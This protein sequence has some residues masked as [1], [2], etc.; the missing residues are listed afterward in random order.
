M[1]PLHERNEPNHDAWQ[2]FQRV[3]DQRRAVRHF[4]GAP[5]ADADMRAILA[6]AQTAPSSRNSQPYQL[7]WV[8]D[9]EQRGK[10]A[11]AC[12][13][14]RAARGAGAFVV[15]VANWRSI[16]TTYAEML[17]HVEAQPEASERSKAYHRG[18]AREVNWFLRIMSLRL[19]GA[20]RLIASTFWP[21][22]S[23]VPAG[24][25]GLHHWATRSSLYAAQT[26]LLAATARGIA[27]CPME[28]FNPLQVRKALRLPHSVV[29]P[30]V[31]AL[32]ERASDARE[33]PRWRRDF[34]TTVVVH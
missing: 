12:G 23:L 8:R 24:P 27:S 13:D 6:A 18:Q 2:V 21:V 16:R 10:L 9:A 25:A 7:H 31:I 22:L 5:V 15:V 14:Q 17:R 33:E 1:D 26:L 30:I 19:L 34:A 28:G 3:C 20:L 32:G 29:I 4:T 11:K